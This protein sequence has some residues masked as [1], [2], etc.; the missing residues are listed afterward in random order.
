MCDI[1]RKTICPARCPNSDSWEWEDE[2]DGKEEDEAD[3]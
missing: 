2:S 3:D 1:C